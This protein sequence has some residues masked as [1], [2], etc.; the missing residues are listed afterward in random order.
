VR[1]NAVSKHRGD[2]FIL[3]V[4]DEP[5]VLEVTHA[6]ASSLGWQPL[7]ANTSE[8]ALRLFRDHAGAIGHVL[9]DLH[10]PGTDGAALARALRAIRTD[11][12]IDI[13]TGDEAGAES[14]LDARLVDGLLVKPFVIAELE[15]ALEP[16]ARA[17]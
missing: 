12:H 16:H 1:P 17:A 14:L 11:V 15:L 9:L 13:M 5:S 8:H 7:L 6:M 3:I 4:D 10:M 2:A